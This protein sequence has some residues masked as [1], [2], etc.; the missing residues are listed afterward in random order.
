MVPKS[1]IELKKM[2]LYERNDFLLYSLVMFDIAYVTYYKVKVV[3]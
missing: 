3:W 1:D 2:D